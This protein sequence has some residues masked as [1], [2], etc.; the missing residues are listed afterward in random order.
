MK[1]STHA[2][3]NPTIDRI[4]QYAAFLLA[5]VMAI[6]VIAQLLLAIIGGFHVF[7]VAAILT[8]ILIPPVLL[9]LTMP[10][11][12]IS[13]AG[14]QIQPYIG[15]ELQ[16]AWE[17]IEEV[18]PYPLLPQPDSEIGRR[19]LLGRKRYR[20]AEGMMLIIPALP[21]HF[22]AAGLLTGARGKPVLVLTNRTHSDYPKLVKVISAR[23]GHRWR[24]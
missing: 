24:F 14:I 4:S 1:K 21:L 8:L 20:P 12:S 19:A 3:P 16:I 2:H 10:Q 22:R 23:T 18:R 17:D 7:F 15:R 9:R 11:V 5:V 13:Q 6:A